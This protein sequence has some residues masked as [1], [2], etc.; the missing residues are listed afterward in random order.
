[1]LR[2]R[3]LHEFDA[4][5]AAFGDTRTELELQPSGSY[6]PVDALRAVRQRPRADRHVPLL[7]RRRA[8]GATC[9]AIL[10]LP[11][12]GGGKRQIITAPP[13]PAFKAYQRLLDERIKAIEDATARPSRATTSCCR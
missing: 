7:R 12:I 2:E 9:A 6:K 4:W 11:R 13:S 5:A 3:G 10:K 8:E 1:M